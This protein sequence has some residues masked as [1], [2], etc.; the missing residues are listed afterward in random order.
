MSTDETNR[1][2]SSGGSPVPFMGSLFA[3]VKQSASRGIGQ[4]RGF[5]QSNDTL[6]TTAPPPAHT[7]EPPFEQSDIVPSSII[8]STQ[9]QP[10]DVVLSSI[11]DSEQH[12][13]SGVVSPSIASID[14][15]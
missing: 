11:V 14:N 2:P 5:R 6:T 15:A 7:S 9:Y 12:Q 4:L 13:T 3:S 10:N 1:P 8:D